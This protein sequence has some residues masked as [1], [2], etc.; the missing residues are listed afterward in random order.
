M[1]AGCVSSADKI[2]RLCGYLFDVMLGVF[3]W[4]TAANEIHQPENLTTTFDHWR[5]NILT[6]VMQW[7][8]KKF[9]RNV[10]RNNIKKEFFKL[11]SDITQSD[12][13][14]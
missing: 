11:L 12:L 8:S 14:Y 3:I 10:I 13:F 1:V 2:T 7:L 9:L 6:K 4:E 5:V